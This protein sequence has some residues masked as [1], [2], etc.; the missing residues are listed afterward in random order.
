VDDRRGDV[1]TGV[2]PPFE[3]PS[4]IIQRVQK[5]IRRTLRQYPGG[6]T[7]AVTHGDIIAFTILWACAQEI[8]PANK[9]KLSALGITDG[10]PAPAS[11]TSFTF[12]SA[13]L[14]LRPAMRYL[15]PY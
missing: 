4:D 15:R 9:A 1:Y 8:M 11:I 7:I 6:H 10:Y 3:Q 14:D 5:F 12:G 13:S 2:A